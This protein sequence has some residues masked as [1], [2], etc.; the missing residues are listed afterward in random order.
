V[1]LAPG[2]DGHLLVEQLDQAAQDPALRLAAEAEQDEI[3]SGQNR[4]DELGDDR[5]VVPDDAGKERLAPLQ[6]ANQVVAD[7]LPDRPRR[8]AGVLAE[9]AE[10]GNGRHGPILSAAALH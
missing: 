1:D 4:V 7:L 9:I 6:L 8:P 2:D 5:L 3:V 10:R